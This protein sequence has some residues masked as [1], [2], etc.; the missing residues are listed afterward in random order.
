MS[1]YKNLKGKITIL[2]ADIV[3]VKPNEED[4]ND[5]KITIRS[6][7]SS[8]TTALRVGELSERLQL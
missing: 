1:A 2:L 4:K 6:M 5:S 3:N 8:G 7:L